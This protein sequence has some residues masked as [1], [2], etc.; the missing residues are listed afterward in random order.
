MK[1]YL[2]LIFLIVLYVMALVGILFTVLFTIIL[3]YGPSCIDDH[4]C[5]IDQIYDDGSILVNRYLHNREVID[6]PYRARINGMEHLNGKQVKNIIT[7]KQIA[8]DYIS[9]AL[10]PNGT[11]GIVYMDAKGNLSEL[12]E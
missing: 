10:L 2:K 7:S 12:P 9:V 3:I 8:M 1:R 6:K 11:L 5:S 4:P